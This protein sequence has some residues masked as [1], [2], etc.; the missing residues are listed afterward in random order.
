MSNNKYRTF[1]S[2]AL[3]RTLLYINMSNSVVVVVVVVAVVVVVVVVVVAAAAAVI[4]MSINLPTL[5]LACNE[6]EYVAMLIVLCL[7]L[8]L[9]LLFL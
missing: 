3:G 1:D 5:V 9:L 2:R 8:L 4:I 7:F 6:I